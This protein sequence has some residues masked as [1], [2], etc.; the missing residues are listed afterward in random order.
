MLDI[1]QNSFANAG[2]AETRAADVLLANGMD[3][4]CLRPY[5]QRMSNGQEAVAVDRWDANQGKYVVQPIGTAN[6]TTLPKDVWKQMDTAILQAARPRLKF[7]GDIRSAGLN[8][9]IP[10]GMGKLSLEYQDQSDI[11]RATVSMDGMRRG[12]S[13]RPVWDLKNMPLPIIH[14][15]IDISVR[16]LE[17]SRNGQSPLDTTQIALAGE[18]V[19]EEVERITIGT[20]DMIQYGGM[21]QIQGA[22]NFAG[23]LTKVM[24]APVLATGAPN[25]NWSPELHIQ[26]ILEMRQQS[27]NAYHY[28]P[29]GL[30]HSPNWDV[31]YDQD[32]SNA[33]GTNTL[34]SRVSEI[35]NIG[36]PMSLDYLEGW[37]MI[38]VQMSINVVRAIVGMEI[39]VVQWDSEGGF[40]KNFKVM[41]ILLP[42]FRTDHYGRTGIVHGVAVPG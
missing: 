31:Y 39:V 26:E 19:A 40:Q 10:N 14:K 32:Y 37:Q 15:D 41:C 36:E 20:A 21:S 7:F 6:N 22:T 1:F 18:K 38:M 27:K 34:R 30:Y 9:V 13:D 23:R 8:Y 35:Q 28:G 33:K 24:T 2:L 17:A 25:P 4:A 29:W 5:R 11:R 3:A 42:Q 16:Q 12:Q